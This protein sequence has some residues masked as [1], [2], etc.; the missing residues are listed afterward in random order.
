VK[1]TLK[2]PNLS[3]TRGTLPPDVTA[4]G[5]ARLLGRKLRRGAGWGALGFVFF[6][7]FAW[8][9]L[10]TQAIAW[11]IGHEAKKA[12]FKLEVEDV[13]VWPWGSVTLESVTWTYE[14]SRPDTPPQQ[15]YMEEVDVS[16]SLLSLLM[17]TIDV[18]AS[19]EREQGRIS[20][21][22]VRESEESTVEF[23]VED[24]P[25][26]DVPK[27]AQSLN[28]PLTGLVAVDVNLTVPGNKFSKANGTIEVT[29]AACKAGDGESKLFVPGSKSLEN[30]L[31][32]PEIDL[33][34]L[35]GKIDV[36]KGTAKVDGA[37]ETESEDLEM[38][39][40][41]SLKLRDAFQKSR[42]KMLLKVELTDAFQ[43]RAEA[44]R[45]MYQ[46]ATT[47]KLS[48]PER[49][50]GFRLE[51]A[52]SAPRLIGI[53]AKGRGETTAERRAKQRKKDA[54]RGRKTTP[55]PTGRTGLGE[56]GDDEPRV[57]DPLKVDPI[58]KPEDERPPLPPLNDD[59]GGREPEPPPP[60]PE[61][62]PPM[63]EEPPPEEPAEP[64]P[65][66]PPPEEPQP[67]DGAQDGGQ[68]PQ[69]EDPN[70]GGSGGQQG[71]AAEQPE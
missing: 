24:L 36:E 27:A 26:Y 9:A 38:S 45:L 2:L 7:F 48:P 14:P 69:P 4:K 31:T 49:G 21:H 57:G 29:C 65:A 15:Y 41:G 71:A 34:T 50:L 20:G 19:T 40:T 37:I 3:L 62:P 55:S 10:P 25:L 11:R 16:V 60:E 5:R 64:P 53:N 18:E 30:G 44:V 70:A 59:D 13:T 61:E 39:L 43:E 1:L 28:V 66:E 56:G 33:G 63:P 68:P 58:D 35:T 42:F 8:L 23:V 67:D 22:Y 6:M 32:I 52:V 54:R 46:G 12:G 17:G 51:G 47:S